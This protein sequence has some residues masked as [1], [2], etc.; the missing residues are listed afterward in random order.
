MRNAGIDRIKIGCTTVN[1]YCETSSGQKT[2]NPFDD[3]AVKPKGREFGK[4][5][6]VPH[7]IKGF[8]DVK[9]NGV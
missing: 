5:A 2:R 6:F 8:G 1:A 7:A 4:K 3:R 9:K